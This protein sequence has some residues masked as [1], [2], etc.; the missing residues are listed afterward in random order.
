MIHLKDRFSV[1]LQRGGARGGAVLGLAL[2]TLTGCSSFFNSTHDTENTVATAVPVAGP[3][4]FH[5]R[6]SQYMFYSD[7]ALNKN[8]PIFQELSDLRD[9]LYKELQLPES[10]T[11]IQVFLFEDQDKYEKY[12]RAKYSELPVRRAFFIEQP[13]SGAPSELMVFTYWG[14][15]IRQDLRHELTHG[16]L[17]SALPSVP[18]WLDEGFAEVF[19]L[20]PDRDGVNALHLEQLRRGPV[21]PDLGRL[22][23]LSQV[24]QMLRPE[25]REAWAWVHMMLRGKPESKAVLLSYLQ[26]LRTQ[27]PPPGGLAAKLKE[28]HPVPNDALAEHLTRIKLPR[29]ARATSAEK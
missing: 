25:Y 7:F 11:L 6:V 28:V 22:E 9:Q 20:P 2:L 15:H 29:A 10:N 23:R 19:E 16:L 18:I 26:Q 13:R 8:A 12:M 24:D 21:Q 3:A 14:E 17:H 5:H 4:K 1:R 27:T